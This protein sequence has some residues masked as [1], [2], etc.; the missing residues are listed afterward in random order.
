MYGCFVRHHMVDRRMLMRDKRQTPACFLESGRGIV[1]CNKVK[2]AILPAI[3]IAKRRF[4]DAGRFLQDQLED[5][6]KFA[7]R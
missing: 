7:R 5:P 2:R 1:C 4:A 3:D 6:L